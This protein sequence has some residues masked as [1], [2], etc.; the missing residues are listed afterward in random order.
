MF[1]QAFES[2]HG[3]SA[4]TS[5]EA[6]RQDKC[7]CLISCAPKT[8]GG[9][10]ITP[11]QVCLDCELCTSKRFHWELEGCKAGTIQTDRKPNPICER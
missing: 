11:V 1:D 4:A 6:P 3:Y 2:T 8:G 7:L 5:Q 9:V 10:L